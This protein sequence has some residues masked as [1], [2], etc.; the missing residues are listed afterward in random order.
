VRA[1]EVSGLIARRPQRTS[2]VTPITRRS[3]DELYTFRAVIEDLAVRR[4]MELRPRE[5]A[6]ELEQRLSLL[7]AGYENA[8]DPATL[9]RRDIDLHSAFYTH[10]DHGRL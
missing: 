5:L 8:V 3:V 2:I 9:A 10:A 1:L 7:I 6:A 4:S